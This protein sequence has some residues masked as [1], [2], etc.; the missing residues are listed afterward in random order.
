MLLIPACEGM[1]GKRGRDGDQWVVAEAETFSVNIDGYHFIGTS[2]GFA[3]IA[4]ERYMT[5]S[6]VLHGIWS[7]MAQGRNI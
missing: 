4:H 3:E 7:L 2:L 6:I 5:S 1:G